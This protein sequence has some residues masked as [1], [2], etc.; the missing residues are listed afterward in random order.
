M[1]IEHIDPE[2]C[3]GCGICV[4]SCMLDVIRMDEEKNIA[5]IKY[6]EDCM[7]CYFCEQDCPEDA[8]EITEAKFSP[9]IV[10]WG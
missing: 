4:D 5:V 8:I 6:P 1:S 2:V 3:S 9:L 10:C 7:M